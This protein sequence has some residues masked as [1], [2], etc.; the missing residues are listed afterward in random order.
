MFSKIITQLYIIIQ[1][2]NQFNQSL[3]I[4]SVEPNINKEYIA[5]LK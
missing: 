3:T 4:K 2:C 1:G 5:K